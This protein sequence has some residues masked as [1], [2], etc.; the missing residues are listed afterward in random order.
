MS[1]YAVACCAGVQ[2]LAALAVLASA[3]NIGGG[4][5]ITQRMLDMFKRPDDPIEH[6]N[7]YA[8]P[9]ECCQASTWSAGDSRLI[10]SRLV[11]ALSVWCRARQPAVLKGCKCT[12]VC[13]TTSSPR[14]LTSVAAAAVTAG[15]LFTMH[16]LRRCWVAGPLAATW[17]WTRS[18]PPPTWS[19]APCALLP[20]PA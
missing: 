20:S 1:C 15:C 17:A 9:G 16:Q 8:I 11:G 14:L 5:T 13:G 3:V 2:G 10:Q 19:A 18:P 12:N 7:L 4:F 6:N